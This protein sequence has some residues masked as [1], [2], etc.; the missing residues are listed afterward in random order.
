VKPSRQGKIAKRGKKAGPQYQ[1]GEFVGV[2]KKG[3]NSNAVLKKIRSSFR[4]KMGGGRKPTRTK[5]AG[6]LSGLLTIRW[7]MKQCGLGQR[8]RKRGAG[9]EKRPTWRRRGEKKVSPQKFL[10][11]RSGRMVAI[12][13]PKKRQGRGEGREDLASN[14]Q[15]RGGG[16][17]GEKE[18]IAA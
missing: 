3:Q 8:K 17:G 12:S 7:G 16:P 10:E 18:T 6:Y 14:L 4:R 13:P 2:I 15:E 11:K 1:G 5:R 9:S